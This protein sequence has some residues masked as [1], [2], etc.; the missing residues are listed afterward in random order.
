MDFTQKIAA[1]LFAAL[2]V[3]A[4]AYDVAPA[5]FAD[6]NGAENPRDNN[7]NS[8]NNPGCIPGHPVPCGTQPQPN[9]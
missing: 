3:L 8:S 4:V 5:A 1:T 9:P 2:L 7:N 6:K